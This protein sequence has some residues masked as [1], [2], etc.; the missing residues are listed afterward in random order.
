V[1]AGVG[2]APA[3]PVV[4]VLASCAGVGPASCPVAPGSAADL[5]A[6]TTGC[7]KDASGYVDLRGLRVDCKKD[8]FNGPAETAFTALQPAPAASGVR[9]TA[10]VNLVASED[11]TARHGA[12]YLVAQLDTGLCLVDELLAWDKSYSS[13]EYSTRWSGS[14]ERPRLLVQAERSIYLILGQEELAS[15]E[16]NVESE[17]CV[18]LEYEVVGGRFAR[19]VQRSAPGSCDARVAP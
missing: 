16:S 14:G 11:M 13:A 6:A 3:A 4:G 18:R 1:P 9:A 2:A 5:C 10:I 7:V 8:P 19:V 17:E 12:S 15:G